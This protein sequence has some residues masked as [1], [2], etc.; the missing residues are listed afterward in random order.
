MKN[1]LTT[2]K[3]ILVIEDDIALLSAITAKLE[4]EHFVVIT[5][6]SVNDV[7]TIEFQQPL[8][9]TVSST[10][11]TTAL[12]HLQNLE[13]IDAI[14]LDHN[15]IGSDDCIDFIVKFK[16]N[17]GTWSSIPIFV[18]SNSANPD[19]IKTY[20]EIGINHYYL[21]AEHRLE[22][23]VNDISVALQTESK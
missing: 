22:S 15:L 16:A 1:P 3:T 2:Q 14:W 4:S 18:V 17:G 9:T 12:D 20:A 19:L 5:A 23:I 11:I 7:F 6:R 8:P 13:K 10:T 21:K